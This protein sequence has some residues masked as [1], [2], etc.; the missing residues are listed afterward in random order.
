M[1]EARTYIQVTELEHVEV[2]VDCNL[3]AE[4][5]IP[6]FLACLCGLNVT[7]NGEEDRFSG[8]RGSRFEL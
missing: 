1:R 3:H 8:P 5:L 4:D 6:A 2:R 7:S